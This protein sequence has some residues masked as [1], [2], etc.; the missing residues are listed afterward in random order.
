[1]GIEDY[2]SKFYF[3]L[4]VTSFGIFL[5]FNILSYR[6]TR[7]M[8]IRG[9]PVNAIEMNLVEVYEESSSLEKAVLMLTE[10][11]RCVAYLSEKQN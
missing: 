10:P 4:A 3:V 8:L 6:N 1:M 9:Y 11:G 2:V 7:E 5:A